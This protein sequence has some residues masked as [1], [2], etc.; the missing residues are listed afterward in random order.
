[1]TADTTT[2]HDQPAL[3]AL[4][5]REFT[6]Y[7]AG[8]AHA[9]AGATVA[10]SAALACGLG[11]ACARISARH[12]ADPGQA[13]SA[14][15]TADRLASGRA[16]L[17]GLADKDAAA[18]TTF[19]A[20]R[21]AGE[22]LA[23]QDRLCRLPVEIGRLVAEAGALLQDFRPLVQVVQDDLEMAITLLAGAAHASTLLL[24]SNLRLWP[25]PTLLARYEPALAALR[26]QAAALKPVPGVR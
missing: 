23:G 12:L 20:Q 19:A 24:D 21:D 8:Q 6:A 10:A 18:I 13:A 25:A 5:V 11:E 22:E 2:A 17:Q 4:P 26:T 14:K 16:A 1:M 7:I 9:M 3:T 15:Q